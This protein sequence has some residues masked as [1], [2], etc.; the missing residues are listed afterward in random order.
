MLLHS[1]WKALCPPPTSTLEFQRPQQVR[2]RKI[3]S[4]LAQ[5]IHNSQLT[6]SG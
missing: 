4:L 5:R 1:L 2:M 6:A 3:D